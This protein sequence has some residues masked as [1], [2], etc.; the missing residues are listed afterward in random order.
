MELFFVVLAGIMAGSMVNLYVNNADKTKPYHKWYL[1]LYYRNIKYIAVEVVL[2]TILVLLY[3]NFGFTI[4]FASYAILSSILAAAS[5]KD[6]Q[7]KSIPNEIIIFS[8]AT[9]L[10]TSALHMSI[11][12]LINSIIGFIVI[13]VALGIL[14]FITKGG[15]GMGDVKLAACVGIFLGLSQTISAVVLATMLSGLIGIVL[16]IARV[17]DRKSTIP[18]APFI[19]TGT[20]MAI[21][22][23]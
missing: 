15:V 11:S 18:F 8:I 20:V 3:T 19:L 21:L 6:L 13:G 1:G 4:Q 10:V 9:G 22:W 12:A 5:V 17:Y 2:A 23:F 16:L 7:S 14:S